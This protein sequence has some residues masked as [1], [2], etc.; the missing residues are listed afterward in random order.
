MKERKEKK[1]EENINQR[2]NGTK[3]R[4]GGSHL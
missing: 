4:S 3:T 2:I 1:W